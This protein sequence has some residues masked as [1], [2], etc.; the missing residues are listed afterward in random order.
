MPSIQSISEKI[1][2]TFYV[3]YR[4]KGFISEETICFE[5]GDDWEIISDD[6]E[7]V[8]ALLN[9]AH[10]SVLD[11]KASIDYLRRKGLIEYQS[12][13]YLGDMFDIY[14]IELTHRGIDLIE[15]VDGNKNSKSSYQTVFNVKL[16]D[17]VNIDSL[18]KNKLDLS[19]LGL[20]G[21]A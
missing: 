16:A 13:G 20:L 9:I 15:G 7:M 18:I 21:L 12:Q 5:G 17:N 14:K 3:T 6:S 4:S 2:L 8:E 10:N 11:I 19:V 1:L